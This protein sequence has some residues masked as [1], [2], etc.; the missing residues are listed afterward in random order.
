M[1]FFALVL[2]LLIEQARPLSASN[3][4]HD[5]LT[6]WVRLMA[7]YT[8][9]GQAW[10]A[11]L[12]WCLAVLGPALVAGVVFVLLGWF[13][14]LL[15]FVWLVLVLYLTLGFRQFSHHFTQV[16]DALH[17]GQDETAREAF[18]RWYPGDLPSGPSVVWLKPFLA[19]S[20]VSAHRHVFGV[21]SAF[22]LLWW[23]GLGPAGAVLYR[24]AEYASRQWVPG[25]ERAGDPGPSEA[26]QRV[27]QEG[28][29]LIDW[30]PARATASAFAVVGN[31]EEAVASWRGEASA[32]GRDGDG[33]V[34]AAAAGALNVRLADER[35]LPPD[36]PSAS[37]SEPA[38]AHLG[39]TV[40]LVWRSV[41]LAMLLLALLGLARLPL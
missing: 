25:R 3:A 14:A 32:H 5:A 28:W 20:V 4:V 11:R 34:L 12:A 38:P 17:N 33:V 16:R 26:L 1:S 2:A 7:R 6:A 8:D 37:R 40:G 13:S 29:R 41:V 39:S 21:I 18:A 19:Y 22:L 27:S 35:D 36:G 30:L 10:H 24:L 23:L 31:F 9:N 15:A